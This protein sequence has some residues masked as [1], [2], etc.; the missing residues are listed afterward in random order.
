MEELGFSRQDYGVGDARCTECGFEWIAVYCP[1]AYGAGEQLQCQYCN[2][3]TGE[4]V[5]VR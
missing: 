1:S 4:I 2:Q 5:N 3:Q